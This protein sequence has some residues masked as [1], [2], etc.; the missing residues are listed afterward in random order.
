MKHNKMYAKL[1]VNQ[2]LRSV[3]TNKYRSR[4]LKMNVKKL[5][6]KQYS[7]QSCVLVNKK[8]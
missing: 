7:N 6:A 8:F 2:A 5:S 3:Q 4:N 1:I